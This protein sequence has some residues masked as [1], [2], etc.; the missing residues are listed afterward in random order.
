MIAAT[1]ARTSYRH[2]FTCA[3]FILVANLYLPLCIVTFMIT[4]LVSA[5]FIVYELYCKVR[6]GAGEGECRKHR[7]LWR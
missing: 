7:L 2:V 4:L 6:L 5:S 3:H 1:H